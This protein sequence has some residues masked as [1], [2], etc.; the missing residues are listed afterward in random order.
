MNRAS[1]RKLLSA[2]FERPATSVLS[3]VGMSPN[4]LTI[5]TLPVAGVSAYLVSIGSLAAGGV[6]LLVA[7]LLDMLDGALARATDRETPFGALLDST[8]D[9]V[10]EALVLVGVLLFYL[11]RPSEGERIAGALLVFTAVVGSS[12]VSYVR[13]RAEGL[14]L[15]CKVGVMTRPERIAV[16]AVGLVAGQWWTPAVIIALGVVSVL[17]ATTTIQRVL[18]VRNLLT[19]RQTALGARRDSA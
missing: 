19:Q 2:Y 16:M 5:L 10:S 15:E 9:R 12:M 1:A 17:T 7:G 13:A 14:D 4:A 6:A 18:H 8:V 11:D 3:S